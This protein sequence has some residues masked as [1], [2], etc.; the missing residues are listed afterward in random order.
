MLE[1]PAKKDGR[2]FL[3][4]P[5]CAAD[6]TANQAQLFHK[7]LDSLV[8]QEEIA[9]AKFCR[10]PAIAVPAPVF[11][12]NRCDFFLNRCIFVFFLHL[13]QMIVESGTG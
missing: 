10:D 3:L 5:A 6:N 12:V 1:P 7:P 11:V 9:L 13:L 2:N 8:V 4:L